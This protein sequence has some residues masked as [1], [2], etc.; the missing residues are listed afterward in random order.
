MD[1]LLKWSGL[2]HSKNRTTC[3]RTSGYA[4]YPP[5][6]LISCCYH[7]SM[8]IYTYIRA[9]AE[10]G[11]T[12]ERKLISNNYNHCPHVKLYKSTNK[13]IN[14]HVFLLIFK[15]LFLIFFSQ[16]AYLLVLF[17]FIYYHFCCCFNLFSI[18]CVYFLAWYVIQYFRPC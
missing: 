4:Y 8:H 11:K 3:N 2:R 18:K 10:I 7:K 5:T 6:L 16:S 12:N 1:R 15:F 14:L 9:Y 17:S 13:F